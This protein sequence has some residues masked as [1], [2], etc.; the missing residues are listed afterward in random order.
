[1]SDRNLGPHHVQQIIEIGAMH[2]VRQHRA[3]HLFVPGPVR[4]MHV[5]HV[6]IVTLVAPAFVEDLFEFFPGIEIHAQIDIEPAYAR[7][8]W[9]S[10]CVH[11]EQR[12]SWRRTTRGAWSSP[13]TATNTGGAI[14]QFAA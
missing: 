9:S 4:A 12:W 7:L 10:I 14:N 6:K 8:W 5:R 2:Y 3:V 13:A 1:M 11:D